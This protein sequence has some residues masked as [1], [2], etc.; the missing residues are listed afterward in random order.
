MKAG[1]I[2]VPI[3][4]LHLNPA[5]SAACLPAYRACLLALLHVAGAR[6]PWGL[7]SRCL[8][9]RSWYPTVCTVWYR[10]HQTL[11]VCILSFFSLRSSP[12]LLGRL[13]RIRIRSLRQQDTSLS[14]IPHLTIQLG[15]TQPRPAAMTRPI[16]YNV[17]LGVFLCSTS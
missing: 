7:P 12:S 4:A 11:E 14:A 10:T 9:A 3:P 17:A 8:P 2:E 13:L 16:V 15:R 1:R 6:P 5:S